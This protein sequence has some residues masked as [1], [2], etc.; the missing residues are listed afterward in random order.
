MPEGWA[1]VYENP[2]KVFLEVTKLTVVKLGAEPLDISIYL[3][4]E[5]EV[6]SNTERLSLVKPGQ[7]RSAAMLREAGIG[8][9]LP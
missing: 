4:D 6:I 2:H 1:V 5:L 3:I 7:P 8:P 9:A